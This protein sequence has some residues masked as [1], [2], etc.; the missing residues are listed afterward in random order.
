MQID[1]IGVVGA[2]AM[3]R[4]IAQLAAQCGHKVVLYDLSEE[5]RLEARDTIRLSLDKLA[6][7]G[8]LSSADANAIFSNI[9]IAEHL[10]MF[11]SCDLVIE[12][13]VEKIDPK[14]QLFRYLEEIVSSDCI[15]ATNTSSLS[16]SA[17]AASIQTPSRFVGLHFFNP[18]TIMPLVEVIPAIQT[19]LA[20]PKNLRRLMERWGKL[21]VIAKDT[22]GFIV[23]RIARPYYS[24][25][26]RILEE[27]IAN[28]V[29]IDAAMTEIGQF[30]MGP[31]TLMDFIGHDVNFAVTETVYHAC[32]QEPRYKPSHSQQ[33]LVYAGYLGRKSGRGF[34]DYAAEAATSAPSED[35]S[36]KQ[37]IFLRVLSM[38]INEAADALY[39]GIANRDD[40]DTAMTKGVNYPKG[41][42]RWADE[43]GISIIVKELDTLYDWYRD[44]RYR[45]SPILR[46]MAIENR[47]FYANYKNESDA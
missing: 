13:I 22:P 17:L 26:I 10:S 29:T 1:I 14:R 18:A 44:P 46:K 16:V 25:S 33:Q 40:I 20:I 11:Q 5:S 2:G 12:A 47:L 41:L 19:D 36:L 24:E 4:A 23:N 32:F 6:A 31:F 43:L 37:S 35:Q 27:G 3:G 15:L 30:K 45:C 8:K 28:I 42:L 39:L 21:P 7:K 34:Y 9:L 38:L